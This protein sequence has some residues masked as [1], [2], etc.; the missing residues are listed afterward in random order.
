MRKRGGKTG[1][2]IDE[3]PPKLDE[4]TR[5]KTDHCFVAA[6]QEVKNLRNLAKKMVEENLMLIGNRDELLDQRLEHDIQFW[7]HVSTTSKSGATML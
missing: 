6:L 7:S 2:L 5:R 1:D 3:K 4:E